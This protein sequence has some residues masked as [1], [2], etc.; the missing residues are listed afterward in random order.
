MCDLHGYWLRHV[1]V[2][3]MANNGLFAL[4]W[5]WHLFMAAKIASVLSVTMKRAQ[6]RTVVLDKRMPKKNAGASTALATEGTGKGV[7]I[8]LVP[9]CRSDCHVSYPCRRR[10]Q[11]QIDLQGRVFFL[12]V[13]QHK[14]LIKRTVIL[15]LPGFQKVDTLPVN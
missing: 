7:G 9:V 2:F 13:L 15:P 12:R 6:D 5:F 8:S 4:L 14:I 3:A 11:L 1:C 10:C